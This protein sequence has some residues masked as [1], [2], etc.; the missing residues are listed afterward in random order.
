MDLVLILL[1]D[2]RQI[3]TGQNRRFCQ[4]STGQ[5]LMGQILMGQILMR[6]ILMGQILTGQDLTGEQMQPP[7]ALPHLADKHWRHYGFPDVWLYVIT[8]RQLPVLLSPF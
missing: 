7:A 1:T 5:I 4:I 2:P 6:Q 8:S 3:L